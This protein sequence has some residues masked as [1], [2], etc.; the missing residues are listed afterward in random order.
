M[1]GGAPMGGAM[2]MGGVAP[3]GMGMTTGEHIVTSMVMPGMGMPG[4]LMPG[5]VAPP[6]AHYSST[7]VTAGGSMGAHASVS[8][9]GG[10]GHSSSASMID[11]SFKAGLVAAAALTVAAGAAT[12]ALVSHR[13]LG[14]A[15]AGVVD[16]PNC[17]ICKGFFGIFLWRHACF[18]CR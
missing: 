11:P 10:G 5:V 8:V 12:A 6:T 1:G 18:H 9:S 17:V 4:M 7:T 15:A 13:R 14:K 16:S 3:M 2:V